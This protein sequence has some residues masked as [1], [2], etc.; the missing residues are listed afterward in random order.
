MNIKKDYIELINLLENN[1][2]NK[3]SSILDEL[4]L[5]C[6]SKVRN[7]TLKYDSEG[8]LTH[9][10][11]YYHKEWEDINTI[12]FGKKSNTKSGYNTMCKVGTNT[13]TKQQRIAKVEKEEVLNKVSIGEI[14]PSDITSEL[15]KIETKRKEIVKL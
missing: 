8:N 7:E 14:D 10:F 13:W 2:D 6:E 9:I 15:E 3:V 12:E 11:C 4:K 5:M 1:K